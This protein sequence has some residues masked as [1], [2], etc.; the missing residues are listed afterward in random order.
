MEKQFEDRDLELDEDTGNPEHEVILESGVIIP[1]AL[2]DTF[3]AGFEDAL[4]PLEDALAIF[5]QGQEGVT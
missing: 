5:R 1:S 3:E 2:P 4:I